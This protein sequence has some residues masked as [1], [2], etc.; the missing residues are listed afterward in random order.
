MRIRFFTSIGATL[1]LLYLAPACLAQTPHQTPQMT[2]S[3]SGAQLVPP[4]ST[5]AGNRREPAKSAGQMSPFERILAPHLGEFIQKGSSGKRAQQLS[6]RSADYGIGVTGVNFPG[7]V[8]VPF[9][10]INDGDQNTAFNSVSG[11]FNNDGKMDV[12]TI[13]SDGTIS[14]LLNPSTFA[15]IGGLSAIESNNTGNLNSLYISYVLVADMDGD[16]F[17]DLVGQDLEN[18]QVVVWIGKGDGT[19]AAPN[20]YPLTLK[21]G[22]TW[23]SSFGNS[24]VVGDFNGDG[25]PD[26]ATL[27]YDAEYVGG[28]FSSEIIEETLLNTGGGR[29]AV[30]A[31][32]D[33]SFG[34]YYG[35][36]Y[37]EASVTTSDGIA[38][39]GLAFLL[40]DSGVNNSAGAGVSV[41]TMASN[42]D[43]TFQ[44]PV[45][46]KAALV[47]DYALGGLDASFVSTNLTTKTSPGP[48]NKSYPPGTPGSG[49]PTADIVFVTG[50][51]A[52]Y[53]APFTSG[54]PT[55]V[56]LLVGY[57]TQQSLFGPPVVP[58]VTQAPA[59][60][61]LISAPVPNTS[62]LNV[63]DMNGDGSQDLIVYTQA[64]VFVF[65]NSGSGEFIAAPTQM[66]GAN[67][68]I[69]QPQPADFDG[70]GYNS[71]VN[72]DALLGEV[73]YFQNLG[74]G[75]SVQ[76]GQFLAAPLI[77]GV[78][79]GTN[80]ELFGPNIQVVATA[81]VNG[82]GVPELILKDN[83]NIMNGTADILLG[84]RNGSG[85]ANQ[86]SNYTFTTAVRGQDISEISNG[87][88]YVEP[89]TITN[90]AGT[91]IIIIAYASEP[92]LVTAGKD[93]KFGAPV[94]LKMAGNPACPM[95]YADVGDVNGDGIPDI[96]FA[97]GGNSSCN[98]GSPSGFYTVLGNADGTF[99]EG[100]FTALGTALYQVRLVNLSGTPGKL[101]LA[102]ID[103][104][105]DAQIFNVYVLPNKGDGT[106]RFNLAQLT[107]PVKD[108]IVDDIV[109]GD[110]N[111]DGKQDLTLLTAG[112]F[113]HVVFGIVPNTSGVLLL[114]GNG[115]YSFDTPATVHAG[116][117]PLW[118]SY[119]D[120]NGDGTPDLALIETYDVWQGGL[121]TPMVK[122]LPNLGGGV[123]GNAVVEANSYE[124]TNSLHE[125][126]TFTGNFGNSGGNDLLVSS[127]FGTV[128]FINRGVTS[129]TLAASSATVDQSAPVTLTAT[130]KQLVGAGVRATGNVTFAAN[131]TVVG[132]SS[133]TNGVATLT[134]A[135]L[136]IGSDVITA[137][138]AG[139]ANHNQASATLA[140]TVAALEPAFSLTATPATLSLAQGATGSVTLSLAANATFSGAV[141][142]TC[143][144]APAEASCTASS[145]NMTLSPGQTAQ[146]SV[147]IA[148]TPPN[149]VY[150]AT[151]RNTRKPWEPVAG[152]ITLASLACFL[153]PRRRQLP[154]AL[155]LL[156]LLALSLGT[157]AVLD[158]LRIGKRQDRQ[159]VRRHGA[160]HLQPDGH[161]NL[162]RA[163]ANADD[164][165]YSHWHISALGD[166]P[167]P[168]IWVCALCFTEL[169][170]QTQ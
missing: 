152:G 156:T 83:S 40:I 146:L 160:G 64:G 111:G 36:S 6:H 3:P 42:G 4:H 136:P 45:E 22:L 88:Y 98:D 59:P 1:V 68:G 157:A 108:Y 164:R 76:T 86:S 29:L 91:S 155:V 77:T 11:D 126:Y 133:A 25:A 135:A 51:G 100:T 79:T 23:M 52:V 147:V 56:K 90:F 109:A 134:T 57:N 20:T 165:T 122:V 169:S 50:D 5:P 26:V 110:Y 58:P 127:D 138:Y 99:K 142:V 167:S 96:V 94:A 44:K 162:W 66:G 112:Q 106:G 103:M 2:T 93:G 63:A 118:G 145:P 28:V 143:A 119:A 78:N 123:F 35:A 140:L 121:N 159:R 7:F 38:A 21:T 71:F 95:N 74:A 137:S 114:P 62:T 33:T 16:G 82:D 67:P 54:N 170:N 69:R 13:K 166:R 80:T 130:V 41:V 87:L 27:T 18:T 53:D 124:P 163:N 116:E 141:T 102:A 84:T 153:W 48:A 139:D 61:S 43:G 32:N 85:Y 128:E 49:T 24:I 34:D 101:D 39:S 148:T 47:Q 65:A 30:L 19:F 149:N 72:V 55:T 105:I 12:A 14:V 70:S 113:D 89:V 31:A 73:A 132:I 131:G 117:Y 115:D 150:Q 60:A 75:A 107:E 154:K 120:F 9:V 158:R 104:N 97:Y 8:G 46:P 10:T 125:E 161:S 151:K 92:L 168:A 144:G 129:L 81:D 17:P 37:D 15:G